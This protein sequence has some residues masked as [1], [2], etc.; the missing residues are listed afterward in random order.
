MWEG[1]YTVW[2]GSVSGSTVTR[3]TLNGYS[4]APDN[5]QYVVVVKGKGVGQSR[6][7]LNSNGNTITI[8]EPWNVIPDGTSVL[9][10]GKY[11]DKTVVYKNYLDGKPRAVTSPDHLA[12]TGIEPFGGATNFIADNNTL[13]ELRYGTSNWTLQE[14]DKGIGPN[15]F[16]I[17]SN[18]KYVNCRVAI[19]NVSDA[20]NAA[21]GGMLGALYRRNTIQGATQAG[22]HNNINDKYYPHISLM[23]YE[24]NN[25]SDAPA[26]FTTWM[27]NSHDRLLGAAG[28]EH[29]LLYKNSFQRVGSGVTGTSKLALRENIY[30]SLSSNYDG[31]F[32]DA[33]VEAPYHVLELTAPANGT[34]LKIPFELWNSGVAALNWTT[35][36]SVPWI[37]IATLNGSIASEKENSLIE[38]NV[39]PQSLPEGIH[40]G[41][42]TVT[43]GSQTKMYTVL[44]TVGSSAAQPIAPTIAL[45]SPSN[46]SNF[47]AP[48]TITLTANASDADGTVSKVE[49]FNGS[50]KIG[51]DLTAPYSINLNDV[52]EGTYS[53]T[54]KATDN[55]GM[56]A[57]S[58]VHSCTI[59]E[60]QMAAPSDPVVEQTPSLPATSTCS[61]TGSITWEYFN[62]VAW[63]TPL[64]SI[65]N[66][67]AS[68]SRQL[69]SFD[70]PQNFA[71]HFASRTRG[72][73]CPPQ[74]GQYTFYLAADDLAELWLSTDGNPANKQKIAVV[75][76]WT[77]P[78][79]YDL[80]SSQKSVT[81][82][83][84]A[85]QRYY[86]EVTHIDYNAQDNMSVAW[87]LPDG[88]IQAP[89]AGA[90]LLPYNTVSIASRLATNL[91][92]QHAPPATSVVPATDRLSVYPNPFREQATIEFTLAE[93]A[94]VSLQIFNQQGALVKTIYKGAINAGALSKFT[95]NANNLTSGVYVCRL[96]SGKKTLQQKMVLLK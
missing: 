69:N 32:P 60:T 47:T 79:Q 92:V 11:M 5:N 6:R 67:Q 37:S 38:L 21:D 31:T 2:K 1:N 8:S 77:N 51:E 89:I 57:T 95:L 64:S 91:N 44:L 80:S 29:Q 4:A 10:V 96:V 53:I 70:A 90:H 93:S 33:V 66:A 94:T 36:S 22:I 71:E 12:A 3:T 40:K 24:H 25:V 45:T 43:A 7:I 68:G 18:N 52:A 56:T 74:S 30:S 86:I 49:F 26:G 41:Y 81:I 27:M 9:L 63:G 82:T 65:A 16:S 78:S 73:I 42:I 85:G 15:Y 48:A 83:L 76:S 17:Y 62:D 19:E 13:H 50:T 23:V 20:A 59:A 84:N 46:G 39:N 75:N 72:Y 35:K 28:V 54:A 55:G 87:K 14:G 34:P 61:G 88:T 58:Q